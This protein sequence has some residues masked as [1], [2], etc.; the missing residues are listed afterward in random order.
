MGPK[1][2]TA[3]WSIPRALAD[4]FPAGGS[5]LARYARVFN[6]VEINSTF[7]RAHRPATLER[8]A[9]SVPPGFQFSVK[10]PRTISHEAAL[11]DCDRLVD[12]FLEQIDSLGERLGP[13]LLQLPP[14][15]AF[16]P[17]PAARVCEKLAGDGQRLLCC[18]P[19]HASWFTPEV[20]AWLA[21]R[22]VARVAADPPRHPEGG[23]PGGWRG[24]A[25][26][27]LHGSPRVYFSPYVPEA[28][29]ALAA[30]LSRET[31]PIVW[32]VFDNTASG[33]ATRDALALR[34]I[35]EESQANAG[36]PSRAIASSTVQT[37]AK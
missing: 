21:A 17:A 24:L 27:R 19:R 9:D 12:D 37:S 28:L 20:D 13:L 26:W 16:D 15:L 4:R 18:E 2:G 7:Y 14:S 31:A 8:W 5:V 10:V 22:G 34:A 6:A 36:A 25:Y 11:A 30:R 3:G 35:V 23:E 32:C 29:G 1:I 33:A